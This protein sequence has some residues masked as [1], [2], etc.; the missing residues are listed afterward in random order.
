MCYL[1]IMQ[2]IR[3]EHSCENI[4]TLRS[5]R[6]GWKRSVRVRRMEHLAAGARADDLGGRGL[7]TGHGFV[8]VLPLT[9]CTACAACTFSSSAGVSRV[10]ACAGQCPAGLYATASG[11]N[12]SG[13][14]QACV[15]GSFATSVAATANAAC[16]LCAAGTYASQTGA[17]HISDC[18]RQLRDGPGHAVCEQLRS[19]RRGHVR[20][21]LQ[22]RQIEW[23]LLRIIKYLTYISRSPNI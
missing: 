10:I 5:N 17:M 13:A 9:G 4:G 12:T 1:W 22:P 23:S 2:S 11:A 19:V 6:R 15:A 18:T 3:S 16:T 7:S 8:Y 21:A 20:S 14:C